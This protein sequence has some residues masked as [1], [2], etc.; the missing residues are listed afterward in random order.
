MFF[1]FQVREMW[2]QKILHYISLSTFSSFHYELTV[3]H[4]Y[5]FCIMLRKFCVF[6]V[7]QFQ[8]YFYAEIN[9]T[10]KYFDNLHL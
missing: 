3:W 2:T 4:F 1:D 7:H 10:F 8:R 9:C 5:L 6:I